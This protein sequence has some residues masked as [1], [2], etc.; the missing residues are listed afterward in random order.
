VQSCNIPSYQP[1]SATSDTL[2]TDSTA[3]LSTLAAAIFKEKK[4]LLLQA[5]YMGTTDLL[6]PVLAVRV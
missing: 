5:F 1:Q 4:S 6:S 2:P 3:I